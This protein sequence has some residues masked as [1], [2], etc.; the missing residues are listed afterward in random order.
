MKKFVAIIAIVFIS[1]SILFAGVDKAPVAKASVNGVI[2][3]KA[4]GEALA[5]VKVSIEEINKVVYTDLDGNF[6]FESLSTGTYNIKTDLISYED[7]KMKVDVEA[8]TSLKIEV[9]S[10]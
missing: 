5:G 6:E 2:V 3:D 10:E 1:S 4:T 9:K 8:T 7:N